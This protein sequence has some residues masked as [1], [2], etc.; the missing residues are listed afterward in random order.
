MI[1]EYLNE[2]SPTLHGPNKLKTSRKPPRIADKRT[3]ASGQDNPATLYIHI[4]VLQ[5]TPDRQI[6]D[7]SAHG[8]PAHGPRGQQRHGLHLHPP[9]TDEGEGGRASFFRGK[10]FAR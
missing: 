6:T 3:P 8:L 2:I 7:R 10:I 4:S 1:Q 5:T 9:V